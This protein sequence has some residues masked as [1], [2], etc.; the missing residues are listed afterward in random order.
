MEKKK[1]PLLSEKEWS[2]LVK[3]CVKVLS[4]SATKK[5]GSTKKASHDL[6]LSVSTIEQMKLYGKG[7]ITSFFKI[8]A[9]K[10]MWKPK[11]IQNFLENLP[12]TL[13][14]ID[15]PQKIDLLFESLKAEYTEDE[16]GNWL[17][18][19]LAKGKIESQL[20]LRLQIKSNLKKKKK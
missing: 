19:L 15:P 3:N 14:Q 4:V 6:D 2:R 20:G 7:S 10:M 17:K 12:Y 8:L 11:E 16:I 13:D 1:A 5:R 18:L 9:F